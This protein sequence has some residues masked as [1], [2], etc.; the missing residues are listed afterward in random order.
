MNSGRAIWGCRSR[1]RIPCAVLNIGVE[2][3]AGKRPILAGAGIF[4]HA[5]VRTGGS[6]SGGGG[7][8]Q[9]VRWR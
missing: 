9:L 1:V 6:R 7:F 2:Q 8:R 5:A 4:C 3:I